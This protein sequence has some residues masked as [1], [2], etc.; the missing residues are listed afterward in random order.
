MTVTNQFDYILK[1]LKSAQNEKQ[2]EASVNM[3]DTFKLRWENKLE[4][5]DM[6]NFIHKFYIEKTKTL[7][8]IIKKQHNEKTSNVC[9]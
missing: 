8:N 9:V 6:L 1:V 3:F 4:C 5:F 7:R 2:I